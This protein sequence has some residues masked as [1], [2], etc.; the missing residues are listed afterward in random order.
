MN[1]QTR[2]ALET[3]LRQTV[4]PRRQKQRHQ[5]VW[6]LLSL[7]GLWVFSRLGWLPEDLAPLPIDATEVLVE[8]VIDGDTFVIQNNQRV[9]LIGIDTPE[10]KHPHRPPEPF[11]AEASEYTRSAIEGKTVQ[12]VFDRER[13]DNYQRILAFVYFDGRFL[14]EELVRLGLARAQ[15]QYPYRGD[16]KR[17]LLQAEQAA[18]DAGLGIWSQPEAVRKGPTAIPEAIR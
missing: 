4:N 6:I 8:R 13:Y 2:R 11:G 5:W 16:I 17:R 3:T 15:P 18:Q 14:N 9:R 12:L 7:A 10:T 1:R